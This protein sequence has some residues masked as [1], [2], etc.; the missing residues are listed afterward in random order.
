[1]GMEIVRLRGLADS[2]EKQEVCD[3]LAHRVCK[4]LLERI[5]ERA[6]ERH[7]VSKRPEESI[8][9]ERADAL[10]EIIYGHKVK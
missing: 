8:L 2:I 7:A 9:I 10:L 3:E 4:D 1:M 5:R 6:T